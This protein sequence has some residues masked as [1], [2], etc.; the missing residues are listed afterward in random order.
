VGLDNRPVNADR[1]AL[2]AVH[3][4]T[5]SPWILEVLSAARFGLSLIGSPPVVLG[6]RA[7]AAPTT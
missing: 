1:G 3:C 4:L 7:L 6:E 5:D 2:V